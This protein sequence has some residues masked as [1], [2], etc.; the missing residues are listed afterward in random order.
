M[1][2]YGHEKQ[3]KTYGWWR[4]GPM[5]IWQVAPRTQ[6][7][8]MGNAFR[9]QTRIYPRRQRRL[10]PNR[11]VRDE[12]YGTREAIEFRRLGPKRV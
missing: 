8:L 3:L 1:K 12:R 9:R 4:L 7:H 2:R 5:R 10:G 11:V 6:P